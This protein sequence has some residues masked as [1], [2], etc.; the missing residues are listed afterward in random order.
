MISKKG[1]N[2]C[3]FHGCW[4]RIRIANRIRE[5][6]IIAD[7]GTEFDPTKNIRIR[8]DPGLKNVLHRKAYLFISLLPSSSDKIKISYCPQDF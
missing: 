7:S 1:V 6:R 2:L 5:S 8:P 4:I 3:Q